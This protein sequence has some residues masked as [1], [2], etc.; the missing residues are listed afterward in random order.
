LTEETL[1]AI[2][3]LSSFIINKVLEVLARAMRQLKEIKWIQIV[4]E[5]VRIYLLADDKRVYI[6]D[7]K[8]LLG[9]LY[10]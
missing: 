1:K 5:E 10:S 4:M 2:A 3:L 9:N 7:L 8:I 6:I